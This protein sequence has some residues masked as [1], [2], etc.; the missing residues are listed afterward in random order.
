MRT[1]RFVLQLV[2]LTAGVSTASYGDQ[3]THDFRKDGWNERILKRVGW[4]ANEALTES[5]Q[6]LTIKLPIDKPG[7]AE[8][9][10]GTKFKVGGDFEITLT[11]Q[12]LSAMKPEKGYGSGLRLLKEEGKYRRA[13]LS[14]SI[15]TSGDERYTSAVW[16]KIDDKWNPI[17]EH[18]P[19]EQKY[20]RLRIVRKGS[21]LTYLV[22][23][24]GAEEFQEVRQAEFGPEVLTA[25]EI[26]GDTG[27]SAQPL[28][29][30][31]T[32]F[33]ITADELPFGMPAPKRKAI[34]S[35]WII[36]GVV[37]VLLIAGTGFWYWRT[38][39]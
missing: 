24:G 32:N 6:G 26:L 22:A 34:W 33:S 1:I 12:I 23:D 36:C 16:T 8:A 7:K 17:V 3:F 39:Q 15:K 30:R 19:A 18:H 35:V 29:V 5:P 4:N 20:G 13:D 27:D 25:I 21:T 31:F 2:V 14:R 38:Q 28:T 10:V 37:G 11:Y 9:G